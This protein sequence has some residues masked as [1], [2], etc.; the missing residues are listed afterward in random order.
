MVDDVRHINRIQQVAIVLK[1]LCFLPGVNL[2]H[3]RGSSQNIAR[4]PCAGVVWLRAGLE[5]DGFLSTTEVRRSSMQTLLVGVTCGGVM[6]LLPGF[7][8]RT[9]GST[10]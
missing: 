6:G 1:A 2:Q 5:A 10:R 8:A 9:Q 7:D 3:S 4:R